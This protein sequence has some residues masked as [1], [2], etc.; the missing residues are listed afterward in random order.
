[1]ENKGILGLGSISTLFYL[2]EIQQQYHK[3]YG[4]YATCPFILYQVDFNEINPFLPSQFEILVPTVQQYFNTM[5]Q[6]RIT[7]VLIPNIT[8]HETVDKLST[9]LHVIHAVDLTL[10]KLQKSGKKEAVVFGTTFTMNSAYLKN[11]FKNKNIK[12]HAPEEQEQKFVDHFRK[13]VY[14]NEHSAAEKAQFK[15]L[16]N[17]YAEKYAVVIACTE[18]SVVSEHTENVFDMAQIQISEFLKC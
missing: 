15:A 13:A 2:K 6:L 8:L 5:Q 1:M 12:L 14:L 10:E 9:D 7:K 17:S 4:G 18:L 16:C 11:K 3:K